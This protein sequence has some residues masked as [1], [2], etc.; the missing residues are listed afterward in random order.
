MRWPFYIS[1]LVSLS[2]GILLGL[3]FDSTLIT[4]V[5]IFFLQL[6]FT[7]YGA[8]NIR[9]GFFID[10]INKI[11]S[12]NKRIVLSFDDGPENST[13]EIL[14]VLNKHGIKAMFFVIGN[15]IG[16]RGEIIKK[17]HDDGHIIGNHTFSHA[18]PFYFWSHTKM[19]ADIL[20][21]NELIEAIT[22][23][24][25]KHF[26][27]PFGVTNPSLAKAISRTG[28][29]TI[30]WTFRSLDTVRPL[31]QV[32]ENRLYNELVG[33]EILLFHDTTAGMAEF[34]DRMIP[35]LKEKGFNF[36]IL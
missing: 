18:G 6:G 20:K 1:W 29:K 7:F 35:K 4:L 15:K 31:D 19:Q 13:L 33:G 21:N 28:L 24:P 27:P 22:K 25:V 10:T 36:V 8:S 16:N 3:I 12:E 11:S 23:N 17:I 26:R 14:S 34:L 32:M 9:S 5:I 2:T 30:G